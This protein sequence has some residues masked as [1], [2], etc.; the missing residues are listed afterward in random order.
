MTARVPRTPG[1]VPGMFVE[2]ELVTAVHPEA[3]LV[4]KR[5]LVYDG[6][7]IFVFRIG[8]DQ[9]VERVLVRALL[10]DNEHIEPDNSLHEGDRLVVAGQ[11]GLKANALVRVVGDE[12]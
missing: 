9:R 6:D 1:V 8:D 12:S 4:A 7:Q 11:A 10:E 5:A 3:L 2:A